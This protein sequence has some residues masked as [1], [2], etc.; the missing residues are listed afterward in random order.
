MRRIDPCPEPCRSRRQHG[1]SFVEV[2]LGLLV[3]VVA[4]AVLMNHLTV[5]YQTTLT[6]RDRVFAYTKAQAILAAI[7][8]EVDRAGPEHPIDLVAT[9]DDGALSRPELTIARD[10]NDLPVPPDHVLSGNVLRGSQWLWSRRISIK[11]LEGVLNR[12]VRYVTVRIL[13]RNL[14]GVEIPVADLSTVVNAAGTGSSPTQVFDVFLVAI[15]NIPGWWQPT[16]TI[17]PH[18]ESVISDLEARNP[19]MEV[20]THWITRSSFGRNPVYRP[21]LNEI[22]DTLTPI[23]EVYHY[24]GTLPVGSPT[25]GYYSPTYLKGR[26]A[27]DGFE[28][29][30][31]HETENPQPYSLADA[32]NHAM[33][34]PEERA[35]WQQRVAAIERRE[36]EILAAK[37]AGVVPPDPLPDMSK[38][39]TLRLLL[40]DMYS[41]P[42]DYRNAILVNMHGELLP[43]PPL[44]N[45]SDAARDPVNHPEVR[46]VTHPEE[47]RTLRQSGSSSMPLRLRVYAH[48]THTLRYTGPAILP[49][50]IAV[51]V[52]GVDLT[53][54]TTAAPDLHPDVGIQNLRGGV[55]VNG[56]SDYFPFAAAKVRGDASLVPGEMYYAAEFVNP[57]PD[58]EKFTRIL[59]HNTPVVAPADAD[60]ANTAM[61]RGL[62][63]NKRS[64]LYW[65]SYVPGPVEAARDF[66]RNLF[67]PG[68]G[69]KNTARWTIALS[70]SLLTRN[71]WKRPDGS[72][73]TPTDDVQL[74]VRTRIWSGGSPERNGTMWPPAQRCQPENLSVTHAWWADSAEDVPLTERF[75]FQGDP[76]HNPYRDLLNGDPD[77]PNGYNWYFDSLVTTGESATGDFPGIDATRLRRGWR[78]VNQSD[79]PRFLHVLRSALTRSRAVYHSVTGFSFSH[80]GLGGEVGA[81]ATMGYPNSIPMDLAPYG[82]AETDG[83]VNTVT[84]PRVVARQGGV[85]NHWMAMPWLGELSPDALHAS[86]WMAPDE[87]GE[88]R[89][90]LAAG[91]GSANCFLQSAAVAYASAGQQAWGTTLFS[92]TAQTGYEGSTSFFNIG[93]ANSTFHFNI[94]GSGTGQMTAEG[95]GL[96]DDFNVRLPLSGA[97]RRPFALATNGLGS[98]GDEFTFAPYATARHTASLMRTYWTSSSNGRTG[99]GLVKLVNPGGTEAAYLSLHGFDRLLGSSQQNTTRWTLMTALDAFAAAGNTG[100]PHRIEQLPRVEVL[101][102]DSSDELVDPAAVVVSWDVSWRRWDDKPYSQGVTYTGDEST[103]RYVLRYSRDGGTTWQHVQDD[104][105]S[106]PGTLPLPSLLLADTGEGEESFTWSL[107]SSSFPAGSYLLRVECFREGMP[108]HYAYHV[109]TF[110]VTR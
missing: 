18:V 89:G 7:Q 33:R 3:M 81:D 95:R 16:D 59:L 100:N 28:R 1:F 48:N 43:M 13:R 38:A 71:V 72:S 66:S 5:N 35:L 40:E 104:A 30:G 83:H 68:D 86:Q 32:N 85:S 25:Q 8:S 110:F 37:Q 63:A 69:P 36:A 105:R 91:T 58:R 54:A 96:A 46:V 42:Q 27:I 21:S 12:N 76:R 90:N 53:D 97:V 87:L 62:F 82:Q 6:E 78:S 4:A 10:A 44:R 19:G 74:S 101:D 41:R 79:V 64:Q 73:H 55:P 39:P 107:P 93:S 98:V 108:L 11:P 61:V 22:N 2:A 70:G 106:E 50:P 57:G 9:F 109:T 103:L 17:P 67:T 34:L 88:P 49:D 23:G 52:M 60:D 24:P 92:G 102:P 47:L 26:I 15:A 14:E 80:L 77:F 75:Q 45:H 84:G 56:T 94:V 31:W 99:S 51:E 20:R 29:N 65:M